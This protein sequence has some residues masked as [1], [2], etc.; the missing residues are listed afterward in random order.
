[1]TTSNTIKWRPIWKVW[2]PIF[3]FFIPLILEGQ[4]IGT[5]FTPFVYGLIVFVAGIIYYVRFKLVQ[6]FI[7]MTMTTI[8]VCTYFMSAR[9]EQIE[10][11]IFLIGLDPGA[12]FVPWL[13]TYLSMPVWL[14]ILVINFVIFY[15]MGPVLV[16][17]LN[18][19]K[20]GIRLFKLAAREVTDETNGFTGRPYYAG[21]HS[22]S[23][24]K[25]IG[26]AAFIESKN[27]CVAEFPGNSIR[28]IFSMGISPLNKKYRNELSYVAFGDDG[29][30]N[31]FISEKDY[32]QYKK[33]YTF[34]ELCELMGKTFLRFAEY[35][36]NN[37]E[38]RII[39]ELRS[40]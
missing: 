8:A 19:E 39:T 1:M 6:A 22:Y 7:L 34:N 40:V 38:N 27:I 12:A 14:V 10:H 5:L 2:I 15:T 29:K 4:L 26:L 20:A 11:M 25:I 13:K 35:Y 32:K 37:N 31:V 28:F 33:Q 18:L 30:I 23:R 3:I 17:A 36:V 16:K 21:E 24:N 9:P